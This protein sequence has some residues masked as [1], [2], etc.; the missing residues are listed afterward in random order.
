MWWFTAWAMSLQWWLLTVVMFLVSPGLALL[1]AWCLA[2][3][4]E[5]MEVELSSSS[6]TTIWDPV[7]FSTV[8]LFET[9]MA[10]QRPSRSF[11]F[12]FVLSREEAP[13]STEGHYGPKYSSPS[14]SWGIG[15]RTLLGWQN[16]WMFRPFILN[17]IVFAQEPTY[18]F[19]SSHF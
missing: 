11:S 15:H 18:I 1:M 13:F 14:L 16:L 9:Y 2:C 10:D 17:G 12:P 3:S 6:P 19:I 4:L 5:V 7:T 8:H